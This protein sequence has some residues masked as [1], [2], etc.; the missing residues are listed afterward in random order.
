[1]TGK[2]LKIYYNT[3]TGQGS[4]YTAEQNYGIRQGMFSQ[5]LTRNKDGSYS[6]GAGSRGDL[7]ATA[8]TRY[9]APGAPGNA[10][11]YTTTPAVKTNLPASQPK[12]L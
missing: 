7:T 11:S 5:P 1:V 12:K 2:Q 6:I 9:T 3:K 8:W 4:V 10:A